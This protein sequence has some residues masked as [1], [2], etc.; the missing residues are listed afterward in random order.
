MSQSKIPVI[1][2]DFQRYIGD[3][4]NISVTVCSMLM[5]NSIGSLFKLFPFPYLLLCIHSL[6]GVLHST[7]DLTL[8]CVSS[9]FKNI[10]KKKENAIV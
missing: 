3:Q 8:N 7:F 5:F 1:Y 6:L 2:M 9:S 4:A 10:K